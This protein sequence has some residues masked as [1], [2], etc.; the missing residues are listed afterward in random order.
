MP[1]FRSTRKGK[2][3]FCDEPTCVWPQGGYITSHLH[4]VFFDFAR[5]FSY[6][7]CLEFKEFN[8]LVIPFALVGYETGYICHLISNARS[9][10]NCWIFSYKC[11]CRLGKLSLT[12][13]LI[14][15]PP[16]ICRQTNC[17]W[18]PSSTAWV[19]WKT[20]PWIDTAGRTVVNAAHSALL[21]SMMTCLMADD[22][23]LGRSSMIFFSTWKTIVPS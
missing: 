7:K 13:Q 17:D 15:K 16:K 9:W 22:G 8:K 10:N 23:L 12:F 4:H 19:Q 5:I 14:F 1:T 21:K 11:L 20:L 6:F 3:C 2:K 18:V